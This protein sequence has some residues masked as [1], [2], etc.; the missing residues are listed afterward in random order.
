MDERL[1]SAKKRLLE[2]N[3]LRFRWHG[4]LVYDKFKSNVE[5]N[6]HFMRHEIL[7]VCTKYK[8]RGYSKIPLWLF[9]PKAYFRKEITDSYY[10]IIVMC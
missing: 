8:P 9:P 5:F 1:G 2:G 10:L 6:Y 4:Y 7:R 3:D